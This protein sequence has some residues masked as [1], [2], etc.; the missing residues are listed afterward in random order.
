MWGSEGTV[1]KLKPICRAKQ[2]ISLF[3]SVINQGDVLK[4]IPGCMS[5]FLPQG[6]RIALNWQII[7]T[8]GADGL[9]V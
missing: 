9:A 2:A 1:L 7:H 3:L 6:G 4:M 8:W 5:V